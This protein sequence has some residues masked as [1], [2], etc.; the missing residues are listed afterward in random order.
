MG[1][2]HQLVVGHS[3]PHLQLD[4]GLFLRDR[5]GVAAAISLHE[6]P[7]G[8]PL[9]LLEAGITSV[10]RAPEPIRVSRTGDEIGYLGTASTGH[11]G[12]GGATEVRQ[13]QELLEE[14]SGSARRT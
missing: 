12:A 8:S 3:S 14:R 4:K 13:Y 6:S 1:C 11:R 5:A 7:A 2:G 10:R 9:T